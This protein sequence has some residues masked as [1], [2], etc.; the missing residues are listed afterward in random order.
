MSLK[1]ASPPPVWTA[2]GRSWSPA[3]LSE[4]SSPTTPMAL[5][6]PMTEL[7]AR[8]SLTKK[9]MVDQ[10]PSR[11]HLLSV[12]VLVSLFEVGG[13]WS[14]AQ[15]RPAALLHYPALKHIARVSCSSSKDARVAP[16]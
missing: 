14:H 2:T 8:S 12:K 10:P 15:R 7:T 5:I 1:L 11:K 9:L 3:S 4:I 13:K 6:F 16:S